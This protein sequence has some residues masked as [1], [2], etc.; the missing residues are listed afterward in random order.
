MPPIPRF[1]V[2]YRLHRNLRLIRRC[3]FRSSA[4]HPLSLY[5][6]LPVLPWYRSLANLSFGRSI[7]SFRHCP[8]LCSIHGRRFW[9]VRRYLSI[10]CPG[11]YLG[12]SN[13]FLQLRLGFLPIVLHTARGYRFLRIRR[14]ACFLPYRIFI[15]N[16]QCRLLHNARRIHLCGSRIFVRNRQRRLLHRSRR[17]H[18]SGSLGIHPIPVRTVMILIAILCP[19][20][21]VLRRFCL[22]R[23]RSIGSSLWFT[24]GV[25]FI[26][27]LSIGG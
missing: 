2:F 24:R 25:R 9:R 26:H 6:S 4:L 10:C 21:L 17:N 7:G 3:T 20:S 19:R 5:P 15:W 23:P 16:R 1:S 18:L 8:G 13:G 22:L 14:N 12:L 27:R 11:N